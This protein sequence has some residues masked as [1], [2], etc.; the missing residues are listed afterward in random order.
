MS[1]LSAGHPFPLPGAEIE[2]PIV[3][4][5]P[6]PANA[7]EI[8]SAHRDIWQRKP[9]LREI[10]RDW[11][12]R[13]DRLLSCVEGRTIELGG[14]PGTTRTFMPDVLSSDIASA[15]W[16]DFVG[17][18]CRLPLADECAANLVMIDVLHHLAYPQRFFAEVARV[19]KPGGRL[20]LIDMYVSP[21][22]WLVLRLF[23]PEPAS[24]SIR[25]L[26]LPADVPVC[27]SHDPWASDQGMTRAIFWK[28]AG[29]FRALFPELTVVHRESLSVLLWPM[30]GGFEQKNRVP[31]W[32][33]PLLWRLERRL[34]KAS[35]LL[36]FRSL[37]AL[38]KREAHQP[39]G[40]EGG[41]A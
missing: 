30:S 10:Y 18:A 21:F 38:E 36:G 37:V 4:T 22:S 23:H 2:P 1:Q 15:S 40:A 41:R 29:R 16:L 34:E 19:L 6:K 39:G 25:P 33:E 14:G 11:F 31:R 35:R 24:R 8:A 7:S 12:D 3:P 27:D 17:D 9:V 20:V 26:A 32:A 5:A 13:I 28:Q